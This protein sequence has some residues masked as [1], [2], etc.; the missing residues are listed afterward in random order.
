MLEQVRIPFQA[1]AGRGAKALPGI[2]PTRAGLGYTGRL[3][4]LRHAMQRDPSQLAFD[5]TLTETAP[6]LDALAAQE[7]EQ[8]QEALDDP[9]RDDAW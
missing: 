8:A 1:K 7:L 6:E 4:L 2:K 3:L 5:Q 9:Q